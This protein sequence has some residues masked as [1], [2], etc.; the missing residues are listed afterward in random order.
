[1]K[2]QHAC[3]PT[4]TYAYMH[5]SRVINSNTQMDNLSDMHERMTRYY[6]PD[7]DTIKHC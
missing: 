3:G 6:T 7:N 4:N 1:M 2:R 5:A